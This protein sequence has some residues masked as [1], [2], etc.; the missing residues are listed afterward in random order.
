MQIM[1]IQSFLPF[2]MVLQAM[3]DEF[4]SKKLISGIFFHT[5]M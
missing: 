5:L 4:N 3:V 2:V 1:Q